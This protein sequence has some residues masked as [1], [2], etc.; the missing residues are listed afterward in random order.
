MAMADT[1]RADVT[2]AAANAVLVLA[3]D[4]VG[5]SGTV[6]AVLTAEVGM[7]E[8]GMAEEEIGDVVAVTAGKIKGRIA[9]LY[10]V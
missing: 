3:R 9:S 1:L 5:V 4:S 2:A 8:V 6:V 10:C 7:A